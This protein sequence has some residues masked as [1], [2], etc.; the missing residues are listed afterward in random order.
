MVEGLLVGAREEIVEEETEGVDGEGVN[1]DTAGDKDEDEGMSGEG[2][3]DDVVGEYASTIS[4]SLRSL[5]SILFRPTSCRAI[6]ALLTSSR[7]AMSFD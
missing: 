4:F 1:K 2:G 5:S 7:D 3:W 6:F